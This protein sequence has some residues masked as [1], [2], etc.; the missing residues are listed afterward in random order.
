[1]VKKISK[2]LENP[3]VKNVGILVGGTASAQ[4]I[5]ILIL[6]LLTRLYTPSEF[7]VLA[8]YSSLLAIVSVVACLR[9]E[10]AIPI[11]KENEDASHL[12]LLSLLSVVL[13]TILTILIIF[14]FSEEILKAT[15][16]RIGGYIWLIPTGVFFSGVY[17]ALQFWVTRQKNFSLVAK[18]HVTRALT[19]GSV[20]VSFGYL[21]ITPLGLLLGHLL[22]SCSGV[23]T[24]FL[25]IKKNN[26]HLFGGLSREKA[27]TTFKKYD[28]FPKYS[29]FE[30]FANS[31]AIQLP[32][33][34]IAYYTIGAEA[35]YL[36]LSMK[37]LSAPLGLIGK[38]LAQVY[39]TEAA[40]KYHQGKLKEFTLRIV[41]SLLKLGLIPIL[42]ASIT[43]PFFIPIIFGEEWQRSGTL[44]SWMAPWFLMQLITSPISMVLH[45]TQNQKIAM[46]LQV[47]GLVFRTSGVVFAGIYFNNYISETY[48]I[49]GF[50]FYLTYF[51][52]VLHILNKA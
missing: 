46:L 24:L 48:A 32:I 25:Y 21:G 15:E 50:I 6:P 33:I 43:A 28:R 31:A 4:L 42:L 1:M 18:T 12:L 26:K 39:L 9:F 5:T 10:I 30:A 3:F 11:P 45:I 52:I 16:G 44:I 23:I 40:D 49:T 17:S 14:L 7:E 37:L 2:L 35:G 19:G 27:V 36:M 20:Q 38:S 13:V 34:I 47:F 41:F 22:N 8:V 51:L 29:T